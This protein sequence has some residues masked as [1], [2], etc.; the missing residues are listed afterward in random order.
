MK[1][2]IMITLIITLMIIT[3]SIAAAHDTN[4]TKTH[5]NTKNEAKIPVSYNI[6]VTNNTVK[7]TTLKIGVI[8]SKTDK[9]IPNSKLKLEANNTTLERQ[10]NN[11]GYADITLKLP[12][13]N[14]TIRI[15][16]QNTS[17]YQKYTYD[18]QL[19][20]YKLN[21]NMTVNINKNDNGYAYIKLKLT[22]TITNENIN[23]AKIIF[24]IS[25]GRQITQTTKNGEINYNLTHINAGNNTLNITYPGDDTYN[26]VKATTQL[27]I[28]TPK[29]N[30]QYNVTLQSLYK[31]KTRLD[32]KV[33]EYETNKTLPNTLITL[34]VQNSKTYTN[35]TNNN[36]TA[37]FNLD[38]KAQKHYIDIIYNGNKTHN[39]RTERI[40]ITIQKRIT[41]LN[42]TFENTTG[43]YTIKA[44]LKDL[45]LN[46]TMPN[47]EITITHPNGT[48]TTQKS[49]KNGNISIQTKLNTGNNTYKI[50]YNGDEN[51]T[52]T[53]KTITIN[54]PYEAKELININVDN[55][56]YQED[57]LTISI[58]DQNTNKTIPNTKLTIQLPDKNI[59]TTTDKTGKTTIKPNL[60]VGT[61]NINIT[62][63][64]KD[65]N[66]TKTAPI[67]ITKRPTTMTSKIT[68]SN[69]AK[70]ELTLRDA[71]TNKTLQ[72]ADIQVIHPQKT[73]TLKTN[74]N[75]QINQT[76]D[77]PPGKTKLTI[78]YP[79]NTTQNATTTTT[80]EFTIPGQTNNKTNTITTMNNT[81]TQIGDTVTLKAAVTTIN[82]TKI[83]TGT[84][85]FKMNGTTIATTKVTNSQAQTT[86][87]PTNNFRNQNVKI[88][89]TYNENTQYNPSTTTANLALP[90]RTA[91]LVVTTNATTKMDQTITLKAVIKDTKTVN[92]GVIIFKING[93]TIKDKNGNTI[94]T[95]VT[96]NT[97]TLNYTIP[98]GWS[99]KPLKLT[100]VYSN[101]N[102]KRLENKTYFNITKTQ[103]HINLTN[104]IQTQSHKNIK[105]QAQ[106]LDEFNHTVV[107][108]NIIAVKINGETI[109]KTN[110]K[111]EYYVVEN[112]TINLEIPIPEKFNKKGTYVLEIVTGDRTAY[113]GTRQQTKLEIQ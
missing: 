53:N 8:D 34:K 39:N 56:I 61:T 72:N 88:E 77:L 69:K 30:V 1:K 85:T 17:K 71:I 6:K 67:N 65:T 90:L 36:G 54:K 97:A 26:P 81:R 62:Y 66:I 15:D 22:D 98:D 78:K 28:K 51:T 20:I 41:D 46:K 58:I 73:L 9:A 104:T 10:T 7:N 43:Q 95:K 64:K 70:L 60:P 45:I 96:N 42:Y 91:E 76:L 63:H 94:T 106:I 112:G 92:D 107:G 113:T 37:T 49:D 13:G 33:T 12:S 86:L 105:I 5:K 93:L 110:G 89:A 75:G 48:Q 19:E 84:I 52:Q 38:E 24:D 82:R 57:K 111:T 50:R 99:A 74:K 109:K 59:T 102:Y 87:T 11:N 4:N 3:L 21:P 14:N 18:L 31:Q 100:A 83:N 35:K 40:N 25:D 2:K 23:N 44:Q 55:N 29:K 32:L 80:K 68:L 79:G 103:T 16:Y 47:K 101:K 27:E 108:E